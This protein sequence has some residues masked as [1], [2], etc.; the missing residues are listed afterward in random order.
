MIN[1][2]ALINP[3]RLLNI[4]QSDNFDTTFSQVFLVNLLLDP[5]GMLIPC[6]K[7]YWITNPK[8]LTRG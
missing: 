2:M 6:L 4:D 3:Q 5:I 1:H 7:K 8:L